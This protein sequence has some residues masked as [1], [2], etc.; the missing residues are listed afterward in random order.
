MKPFI[1]I[2][3][4]LAM[5]ASAQEKALPGTYVFSS[6]VMGKTIKGAPYSADEITES[7][8]VLADGTRISHQTKTTVYRDSEGRVRRESPDRIT[9]F[10]P[11]AGF[12]YT[13][14]PT[15]RTAEQTTLG[16][17]VANNK[18]VFYFKSGATPSADPALAAKAEAAAKLDKLKAEMAAQLDQA[19]A[20][21][22][23]GGGTMVKESLGQQVIEGVTADGTRATETIEAGAIGND[24]PIHVVNEVWVSA[25]LKTT[26]M[27][28]HS[29]PR[30]GEHTFRLTNVQRGDPPTYLFVMPPDYQVVGSETKKDQ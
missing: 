4:L 11:V 9:I 2:F 10:D 16:T 5:G 18:K 19:A 23:A 17:L 14:D 6:P 12:S 21:L 30:T 3:G 13:L 24:R 7:T 28:K 27:T 8:Q 15:A 20:K 26:V 29:D 22:A 25:D 1:L